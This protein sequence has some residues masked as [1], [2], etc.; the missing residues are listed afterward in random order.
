MTA[1]QVPNLEPGSE[2]W[3]A[4]MSASKVSA[5][6]GLS[7]YDSRYSLWHKMAGNIPPEPSDAQ[8]ESGH[9]LEPAITAWFKDQHPEW[10]V[11]YPGGTWASD[12]NPLY[13][14]S[15]DGLVAVPDS[16][17]GR[18]GLECKRALMDWE[19]GE[20]LTDDVPPGYRAQCQWQMFVGDYRRTHLAMIT[21]RFQFREYV[22]D[23]DD[24]DA[25]FLVTEADRFMQSL[26]DGEEPDIDSHGATYAAIKAMHP[27]IDGTEYE[28]DAET[29]AAYIDTSSALK[30]AEEAKQ[31][32]T[33]TIATAM[34][35]A[36]RATFARTTY[37]RRQ[38][39]K[40]PG[41][42]PYLVATPG[43]IKKAGITV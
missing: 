3:L 1:T 22:I 20:E 8:K 10:A 19:W 14:A 43:L 40:A 2:P 30:Q 39:K 11:T 5:M 25:E 29:A 4:T 12:D 6:L 33:N 13:V 31:F 23:A 32:V 15:P 28:L 24:D 34:G 27:L 37:V 38:A 42:I 9:Y 16:S 17:I 21:T 7:V 36:Q 35:N 18:R 26:R 41:S